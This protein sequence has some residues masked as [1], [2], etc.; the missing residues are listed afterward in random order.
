MP[1]AFVLKGSR[2]WDSNTSDGG[3]HTHIKFRSNKTATV[4]RSGPHPG[5]LTSE[6]R[7]PGSTRLPAGARDGGKDLGVRGPQRRAHSSSG[8]VER[9][10]HGPSWLTP[11]LP[12]GLLPA[13]LVGQDSS[14]FLSLHSPST[15]PTHCAPPP[16]LRASCSPGG[17]PGCAPTG[18]RGGGGAELAHTLRSLRETARPPLCG[19]GGQRAPPRGVRGRPRSS[20]RQTWARTRLPTRL[21]RPGCP[22]QP[23]PAA[24]PPRGSGDP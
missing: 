5:L 12:S 22:G 24:K 20:A 11:R 9:A 17:A 10:P 16:A 23:S 13:Q 1:H 19:R 15:P 3:F 4:W 7:S 8:G 21:R 14:L 2:W 18:T 6:V